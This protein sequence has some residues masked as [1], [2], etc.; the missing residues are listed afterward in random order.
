MGLT[1]RQFLRLAEV[2]KIFVIGEESYQVTC[3]L[4][5]VMSMIQGM[6]NSEEFLIIDIIVLFCQGEHLREIC[7]GMK[8]TVVILLHEYP[9]TGQERG[10]GHD[11]EGMSDIGKMEYRSGLESR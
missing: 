9:P 11:N 6:D 7:T 4:E 8:I 1:V 10:I 3:A 5:V 2:C